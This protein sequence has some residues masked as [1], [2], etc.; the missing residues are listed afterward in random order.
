MKTKFVSRGIAIG[1][2]VVAVLSIANFVVGGKVLQIVSQKSLKSDIYQSDVNTLDRVS[3]TSRL[4]LCISHTQSGQAILLKGSNAK[5]VLPAGGFADVACGE[6]RCF[7]LTSS[8]LY[9]FGARRSHDVTLPHRQTFHFLDFQCSSTHFCLAIDGLGCAWLFSQKSPEVRTKCLDRHSFQYLQASISC[10]SLR[11]DS[12]D[13][14]FSDGL[15]ASVAENFHVTYSSIPP[16]LLRPPRSLPPFPFRLGCSTTS[17]NLIY[18]KKLLENR[19]QTWSLSRLKRSQSVLVS[20]S[21]PQSSDCL[22][23]D[24]NGAIFQ[25]TQQR[26]VEVLSIRKALKIRVGNTSLTSFECKRDGGCV[27]ASNENEVVLI[28]VR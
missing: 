21:C 10:L 6:K 17:C 11:S 20:I 4:S 9:I 3:C 28:R 24:Q 22:V 19:H 5:S 25:L 14:A 7:G 1:V 18:G 15:Y 13:V 2:L 26:Q 8:R 27:A 23:A 16:G 12:C